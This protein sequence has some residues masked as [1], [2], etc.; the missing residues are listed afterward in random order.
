MSPLWRNFPICCCGEL[1][2]EFKKES[3][4]VGPSTMLS[5]TT[6]WKTS[7]VLLEVPLVVED[8]HALWPAHEK[9]LLERHKGISIENKKSEGAR[10]MAGA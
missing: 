9:N 2:K 8:R 1:P 4:S 5:S 10:P 7:Q 6:L 3:Y